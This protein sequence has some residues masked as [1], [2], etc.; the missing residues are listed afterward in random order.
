MTR[1]KQYLGKA[2]SFVWPPTKAKLH[3]LVTIAGVAFAAVAEAQILFGDLGLTTTGKI[4]GAL[5]TLATLL[6]G[7]K[8][9]APKVG[10]AIDALPIP[11]DDGPS[12]NLDTVLPTASRPKPEE[13]AR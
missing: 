1:I 9:V 10:V 3:R 2:A 7:W 11:A 5:G 13:P 8:R 4:A 12:T 6:A